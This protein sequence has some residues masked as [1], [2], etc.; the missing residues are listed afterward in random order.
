[1]IGDYEDSD[2]CLKIR[3]MGLEI[4]Y[5][6][7]SCL[8]H[9]ERR[10]IRRSQDYMRGVASHYNAWLHTQRWNDEIEDLMA[11]YS[12]QEPG[13]DVLSFDDGDAQRSAA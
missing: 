1:V 2:L 11:A 9:F 6:P 4:A 12:G 3:R 8:Y 5:E 10:S 7:A 13:A